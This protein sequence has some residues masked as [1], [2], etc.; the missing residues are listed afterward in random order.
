MAAK[1]TRQQTRS[2][3]GAKKEPTAAERRKA[4]L[5]RAG[6]KEGHVSRE[7][8][9]RGM[10]ETVAGIPLGQHVAPTPP[11]TKRR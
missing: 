1:K 7:P 4:E 3:K 8:D 6:M 5:E 9:V 10:Q 2:T 11:R